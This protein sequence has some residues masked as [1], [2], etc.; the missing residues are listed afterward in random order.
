MNVYKDEA[1]ITSLKNLSHCLTILMWKTSLYLGKIDL[2]QLKTITTCPI[3]TGPAERRCSMCWIWEFPAAHDKDHG[4]A[5]GTCSP[6]RFMV[7]Q[8]PT[9]SIWRH[10]GDKSWKKLQPIATPC[11]S[12]V[13]A[14]APAWSPHMSRFSAR[15][16]DPWG[17]PAEAVWFWMMM[18][19]Q[20]GAREEHEKIEEGTK[21]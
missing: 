9:C 14:G 10:W 18:R 5:A 3:S 13:S 7:K 16:C 6:W 19:T 20:A 12:R 15:T 17:T 11:Q 4:E 21:N 1:S 2:L 8:R